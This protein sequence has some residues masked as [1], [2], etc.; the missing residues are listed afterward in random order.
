VNT[1]LRALVV[2]LYRIETPELIGRGH[3]GLQN[4][5]G[6]YGKGINV[7]LFYISPAVPH[8]NKFITI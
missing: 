7:L 2:L 1:E 6:Y 3:R 8:I 5:P 4:Q